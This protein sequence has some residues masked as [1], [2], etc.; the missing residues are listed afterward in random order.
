M[1]TSSQNTAPISSELTFQELLERALDT[2]DVLQNVEEERDR[3]KLD[4]E[5]AFATIKAMRA[6]ISE[7]SK[8]LRSIELNDIFEDTMRNHAILALAKLQPFLS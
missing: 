6:A 3:L 2:A 7:A 4:Y 8:I 5:A 1:S